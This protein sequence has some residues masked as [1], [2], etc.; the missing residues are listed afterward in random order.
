MTQFQYSR[1]KTDSG[2]LLTVTPFPD[3]QEFEQFCCEF[4]TQEGAT[5]IS[6]DSGMDRHQVRFSIG[7][8]SFLMHFEHYTES[9][10]VELECAAEPAI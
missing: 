4:I 3:W 10:W 9:I 2:W 1:E 7:R 5:L 8:Q 6:K